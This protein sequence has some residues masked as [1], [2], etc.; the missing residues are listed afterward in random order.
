[1]TVVTFFVAV[2]LIED[3]GRPFPAAGQLAMLLLSLRPIMGDL[4]HGN[5]NLLILFLVIASLHALR[6]GYALTS[7][8]VLGLA[9][10][11]KLTPA[12][13]VPYF[14]WKRAWRTLAGCGAGL[15]LFFVLVPGAFLGQQRN[16]QLLDSWVNQM[17][18]PYVV[19][20][21]VTSEHPN[22]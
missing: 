17:I 1:M 20:G 18:A 19:A 14:L 9:I 15:V 6:R 12:L 10:A 8:L 13:F 21:V 16:L 4:S 3:P 7:G 22:Q 2:R 11:C 5:V